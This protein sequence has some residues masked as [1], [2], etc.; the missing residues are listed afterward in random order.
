MFNASDNHVTNVT[1]NG[2]YQDEL[3]EEMV[4]AI[5]EHDQKTGVYGVNNRVSDISQLWVVG[6][7]AN[8]SVGR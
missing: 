6:H 4:N 8:A 7:S 1:I 3:K 2:V 5:E